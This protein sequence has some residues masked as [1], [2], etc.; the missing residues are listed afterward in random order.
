M[1]DLS[2]LRV[3]AEI[4]ERDVLKVHVGQKALV[5]PE[6]KR[7]E[8]LP[9]LLTSIYKSLGR[10]RV[11][12]DDPSDKTDREVLEALVEFD[13]TPPRWPLGLRVVVQLFE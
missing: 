2:V 9:G 5:F 11:V 6:G 10:K 4:D 3:R 7:E 1:A 8:A 13:R 12:T